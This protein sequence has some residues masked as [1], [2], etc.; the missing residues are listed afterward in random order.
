MKTDFQ[1]QDNTDRKGTF[2]GTINYLAPEMIENNC[3][4]MSTDL[5]SMGCIIFKLLTGQ[6]PF[7][8]TESFKVFKK[9]LSKDFEYPDFLSPTAV[10][11]I[12]SMI[13]INP[14]DRLGAPGT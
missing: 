3:A 8:G 13:M 6:V 7:T 12:D 10:R 11:L 1:L 14:D 2:V 9:I 5:W 4:T